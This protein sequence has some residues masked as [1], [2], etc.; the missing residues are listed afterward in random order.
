VTAGRVSPTVRTLLF[1]ALLLAT[2]AVV[3]FLDFQEHDLPWTPP[4]WVLAAAF[5]VGGL[6]MFQVELRQ[7]SNSFTLADAPLLVGLLLVDPLTLLV[8]RLVGECVATLLQRRQPALKLVFNYSLYAAECCVAL[9]VLSLLGDPAPDD[10]AGWAAAAAAVMTA[11]VMSLLAVS[12]VIRWHGG[13]ARLGQLAFLAAGAAVANVTLGLTAVLLVDVHPAATVLLVTLAAVLFFAFQGHARLQQRYAGL[14]A[15]HDFS[16][17]V[18]AAEEQDE[19]LSR[20]LGSAQQLMRAELAELVVLGRDD[21]LD[22]RYRKADDQVR[23]V[24]PGPGGSGLRHLAQ[25]GQPVVI[26]RGRTS[27]PLA[28]Y[29]RS[30]GVRDLVLVPL[31]LGDGLVAIL[32]VGG[33]AAD[34]RSFDQAD[35]R[36][37]ATL[38][39][40]AEL[41]LGR[42]RL[43]ARLREEATRRERQALTDDVTGLP[44]RTAFAELA[45]AAVGR[46]GRDGESR[47]VAIVVLDLAGFRQVNDTLGHAT[48]DALLQ[49]FGRRLGSA[50]RDDDA[51]ARLGSDDFAVLLHVRDVAEAEAAAKRILD[52]VEGPL[53]LADVAVDV[54]AVVGLAVWPHHGDD[55]AS[56]LQR[57]DVAM[58]QAKAAGARIRVYR[59]EDDDNSPRRL[60]L[61]ADLRRAVTAGEIHLHWM[62]KVDLRTGAVSGAE[63]LARWTHPVH[64]RVGPDEFV[65]VAEQTAS[66]GALTAAVLETALEQCRSWDEAGLVIPV[67][68]NVSA[69]NLVDDDFADDVARLLE[70]SGVAP[71]RLTLELTESSVM[72]D[73]ARAL[74]TLERLGAIG[75]G[76]SIDDFG[77]GWSSLSYLQRLPVDELKVDRS[78][79]FRVATDVGDRAIV[80]SV[81]DLGHSLG[82]RVVAEGVESQDAWH[83]LLDLGCDEAQGYLVSRPLP[84]RE[85]TAWLAGRPTAPGRSAP[86][87]VVRPLRR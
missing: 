59:S 73:S 64:G 70:R 41:A 30:L 34:Q 71:T 45:A 28:E 83:T 48:G 67:A 31:R 38:A 18:A 5:A 49:Q 4:L 7:E 50:V 19:I 16:E 13:R 62:P 44:N 52:R 17:A 86:G 24:A 37:F 36:E 40:Q 72:T 35:A 42:G 74:A 39:R 54:R 57:A 76:L 15:L 66:I 23:Q 43:L 21:S 29:V 75:V 61:A 77:T 87:A 53:P 58:H 80:R 33:R 10:P 63:A 82:L 84:P 26:R 60:T 78:F 6:L 25:A 1:S 69:R 65:P 55:A 8:A 46:P 11:D 14:R 32:T 9:S 56:A 27:A 2:L 12:L 3:P 20:T 85:L 79:V 47:A 22:V 81:V 68:V 51:V